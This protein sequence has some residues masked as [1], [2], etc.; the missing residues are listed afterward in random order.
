MQVATSLSSSAAFG[1]PP[2]TTMYLGKLPNGEGSYLKL[3]DASNFSFGFWGNSGVGKTFGMCQL[4]EHCYKAGVTIVIPDTQGD[5]GSEGSYSDVPPS[6][7]NEV[8][9]AYEGGD[10]A[11]NLLQIEPIGQRGYYAAIKRTVQA[12]RYRHKAIGIHQQ[13]MLKRLLRELYSRFGIE[14]KDPSTWR[15]PSPT[16]NDLLKLI[17][18]KLDM[19]ETGL[20]TKVFANLVKLQKDCA[21]W[22]EKIDKHYAKAKEE[23]GPEADEARKKGAALEAKMEEAICALES[24]SVHAVRQAATGGVGSHKQLKKS[25]LES[26]ASIVYEFVE[27]GLYAGRAP[28]SVIPGKINVIN[29]KHVE[30]NDMQ[31]LFYLM[32]SSEFTNAQR[33]CTSPNDGVLRTLF[34]FDEVKIFADVCQDS[35]SPLPRIV[36]EGRKFGMGAL[37]GGQHPGQVREEILSAIGT[38]FLYSVPPPAYSTVQKVFGVKKD[39][40]ASLTPKRDAFVIRGGGAMTHELTQL[41]AY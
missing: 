37:I 20:P 16:V 10:A 34:A 3:S 25:T 28:F 23:H 27:T 17:E 12:V 31:T 35:M 36:T 8:H 30:V 41:W 9:F 13:V 11:F 5:L 22:R 2:D 4:I 26:L 29:L 6:A 38:T 39:A 15:K 14:Q 24:E 18:Y 33:T 1:A 21:G 19:M 32:M 40:L 7:F